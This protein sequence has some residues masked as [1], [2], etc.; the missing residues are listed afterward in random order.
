MMGADFYSRPHIS[1][2]EVP[3]GIGK[4]CHIEG[5]ILG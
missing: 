3:I 2:D 1:A 5:A 4:N